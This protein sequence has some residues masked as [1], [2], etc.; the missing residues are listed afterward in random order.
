MSTR[1]ALIVIGRYK[2]EWKSL[3]ATQQIN[4][5]ERVGKTAVAS[6]L[7]PV[8]GYRLT[9][10]PGTFIEV[11]E[12]SSQESVG[13]AVKDLT[14]MGYTRFVDARWMIGEREDGDVE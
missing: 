1:T 8:M 11:W 13:R 14:A 5:I 3:S 12:S 6:G 7:E 2:E 4:F 9:A 10:T